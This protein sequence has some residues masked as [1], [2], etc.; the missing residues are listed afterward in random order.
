[1]NPSAPDSPQPHA[2]SP[3][4]SSRPTRAAQAAPRDGGAAIDDTSTT[5]H[6]PLP[7]NSRRPRSAMKQSVSLVLARR[8]AAQLSFCSQLDMP[9]LYTPPPAAPLLRAFG[10]LLF[11]LARPPGGCLGQYC[12]SPA[13][14]PVTRG[15]ERT[16]AQGG[17]NKRCCLCKKEDCRPVVQVLEQQCQ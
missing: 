12:H 7:S 16:S 14:N 10:S 2:H 4:S 5:Q 9:R 13:P 3:T 15:T 17:N 8:R 11:P 6:A 1:M